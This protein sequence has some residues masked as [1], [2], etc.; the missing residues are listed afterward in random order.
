MAVLMLL[1]AAV[2][3]LVDYALK[4]EA[5]RNF[6]TD[7]SLVRFF[8]FFYASC[9][10]LSFGIQTLTGDRLL[11]RFGL[12]GAVA[13]LPGFVAVLAS[14]GMLVA[15]LWTV[16]LARA[17]ENVASTA[18][19][20]A[21]F[22]LLYTPM[23]TAVKRPAKVWVDV[24]AGSLG[25][26][27]GAG[28]VFALLFLMT[29]LP[30]EIVMAGAVT[31]SLA[32][33]AVV[34]RVRNGYVTELTDSL[35]R[36]RVEIRPED[37]LDRTTLQTIAHSQMS[38]SRQSLLEQVRAF[39]EKQESGTAGET[40]AD[41]VAGAAAS[42]A[43]VTGDP[44]A[45]WITILASGS[46]EAVIEALSG[47]IDATRGATPESR[48]RLVAWVIPLLE[49]DRLARVARDF[50]RP[51]A[52][53]V[54]GQLADA[55][56]DPGQPARMRTRVAW[57]LGSLDD[58]RA[59]DGL[60]RAS[61]DDTLSVRIAS[62]RAITR[63]VSRRPDLAPSNALVHAAAH[64]ELDRGE[65]AWQ[66]RLRRQDDLIGERSVLLSHQTAE[67]VSAGLEHVFTLLAIPH[68]RQLMAS[69]LAGLASD[70]P[71]L[72]G[73]AL[74]LLESVLPAAL[75]HALWPRLNAPPPR[76]KPKRSQQQVAQDLLESTSSQLIDRDA[77][78]RS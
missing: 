75:R 27:L 21:G 73:T 22:Q 49:D 77:L 40:A 65:S 1:V 62:V 42:P 28:A 53:R 18:F 13:M 8:A 30:T 6:Q 45:G 14:P 41:P 61:G 59:V 34:R 9:G 29:D 15:K 63:I 5:A 76:S 38:L 32:A 57:V 10:L 47:G 55:L 35:R 66:G 16:T 7:E 50:L 25:D 52:P 68:E 69:A 46:T 60:W 56:L 4:A 48:R 24:A 37:A 39:D 74:E 78:K 2:D 54:A 58:A 71:G 43:V 12:A 19:F 64:R 3:T 51:I 67:A 33:L 31:V 17:A 20:R 23:A 44:L 36:G 11:R 26:I 70:D 72:R